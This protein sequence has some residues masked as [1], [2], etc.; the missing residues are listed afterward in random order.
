M[1]I[2]AA[3]LREDE[4]EAKEETKLLIAIHQLYVP[5]D[6]VWKERSSEDTE[7]VIGFMVDFAIGA[8]VQAMDQARCG[9]LYMCRPP[10]HSPNLCRS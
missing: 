9:L 5:I 7:I 10:L 4:E 2:G 3:P 8:S 1:A 6:C